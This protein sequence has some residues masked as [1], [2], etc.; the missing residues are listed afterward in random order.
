MPAWVTTHVDSGTSCHAPRSPPSGSDTTSRASSDTP[1]S[2]GFSGYWWRSVETS[3]LRNS[4]RDRWSLEYRNA[5]VVTPSVVATVI[6]IGCSTPYS[7]PVLSMN[8]TARATAAGGSCSRPK[9]RARKK[10]TSESVDP[11]IS[12]KSTGSTSSISERFTRRK[13]PR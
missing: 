5:Q 10:N 8:P 7:R 4:D 1:C 6:W 13:S 3:V 12:G 2:T 11:A 9:V